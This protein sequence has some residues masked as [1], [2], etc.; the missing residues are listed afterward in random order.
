MTCA[1]IAD[2]VT[3]YLETA[4]NPV[5]RARFEQHLAG[6]DMCETYLQQL[7]LTIAELGRLPTSRHAR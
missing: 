7:R 6:C 1:Q 4:M 2:L 3:E 5:D